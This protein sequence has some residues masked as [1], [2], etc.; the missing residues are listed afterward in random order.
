MAHIHTGP[1]EHDTTTSAYIVRMQD[2]EPLVLVH[3]HRKFGKLMQAG[4]HIELTE[5]PWSAVA[6]ELEEETGYR[7]SELSVLQPTPDKVTVKNAVVHPVP[8]LVNT[9]RI[10]DE[11]FHT[12]LCYAFVARSVPQHA[13]AEGESEDL[14]WLTLPEYRQAVDEGTALEDAYDIYKLIVEQ[15]LERYTWVHADEFTTD[16]PS[17]MGAT[18]S[19]IRR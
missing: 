2:D 7:L 19:I 5:T 18:E 11:H 4:G 6:H 12:D 16:D 9:H 17:T 1:Q 15:Y 10:S 8:L 13:P 3:M 14:R